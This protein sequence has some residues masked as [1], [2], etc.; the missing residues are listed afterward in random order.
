MRIWELH[1]SLIHFPIAF[2]LGGVAVEFWAVF[3][4]H[5]GATRTAA[6]LLLAGMIL[7]W[8]AALAGV[9]AFFTAPHSGRAHE[10]MYYHGA[11]A[12]TSMVL[13]TWLAVVRWR[14]RDGFARPSLRLLAGLASLVL[15][16]TGYLG[17]YL[18]YHAAAGIER[19]ENHG[20]GHGH[21]HSE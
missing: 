11:A 8:L 4:K 1:P 14:G 17:G 5:P 12:A 13:F 21:G 15:L 3:K 19:A 2:L 20:D 7:G 18:V 6:G 16:G 9:V 10:L